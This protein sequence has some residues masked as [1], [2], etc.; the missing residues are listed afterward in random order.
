MTT[1]RYRLVLQPRHREKTILGYEW[2]EPLSYGYDGN[3]HLESIV[4]LAPQGEELC[5]VDISQPEVSEDLMVFYTVQP[6]QTRIYKSPHE[7]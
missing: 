5:L 6:V 1:A 4:C 7:L 3:G 2:L